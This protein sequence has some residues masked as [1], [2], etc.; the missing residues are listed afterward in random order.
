MNKIAEMKRQSNILQEDEIRFH[1]MTITPDMA[2]QLLEHNP[3]WRSV[4]QD[5]VRQYA[6]DMKAGKWALTHQ[7]IAFKKNGDIEDGQHRLWAIVEADVPVRMVV[8]TYVNGMCIE[9]LKYIDC[10]WN[11]TMGQRLQEPAAVTE[12]Y[13]VLHRLAWGPDKPALY[14]IEKL[15]NCFKSKASELVAY[16]PRSR[17]AGYA[18]AGFR[19]AAVMAWD[20]GGDGEYILDLYRNIA[21]GKETALPKVGLSL[22]QVIRGNSVLDRALMGALK[23]EEMAYVRGRYVFDERN[24]D[25]IVRITDT[26]RQRTLAEART[27]I[28]GILNAD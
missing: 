19:T 13:Q 1:I 4:S 26:F 7:G 25:K 12:V 8:A 23:R 6:Q 11:R 28:R 14:D 27:K 18:V 16:C 17:R 21:T 2:A 20:D 24:R 5:K 9:A 22:Y 15:S 10:G 3:N